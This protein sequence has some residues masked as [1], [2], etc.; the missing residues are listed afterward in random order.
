MEKLREQGA[1][2][3]AQRMEKWLLSKQVNSQKKEDDRVKVLVGACVLEALKNNYLVRLDN[4]NEL[5]A[6]LN[7][8]LV[9]E[10]ER[11]AILGKDNQGSVAFWRCIYNK[12]FG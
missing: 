1:S 12:P 10:P 4:P 7:H 8:F 6:M 2:G 3:R 9:R 11:V 5:L